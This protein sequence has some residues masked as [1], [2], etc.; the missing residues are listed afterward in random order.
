MTVYTH[1]WRSRMFMWSAF[2]CQLN[3]QHHLDLCH[4]TQCRNEQ[5]Y[6]CGSVA[7]SSLPWPISNSYEKSHQSLRSWKGAGTWT[8]PWGSAPACSLWCGCCIR[9]KG[10]RTQSGLQGC[11]PSRH[12]RFPQCR[13]QT[14]AGRTFHLDHAC[15]LRCTWSDSGPEGQFYQSHAPAFMSVNYIFSSVWE[16][17]LLQAESLAIAFFFNLVS[18]FYMH[19]CF[20][21]YCSQDLYGSTNKV[22][23]TT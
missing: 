3:Y 17:W 2:T 1:Q 14:A 20:V 11:R 9:R 21:P 19:F 4:M 5:S 13:P 8:W 15:S 12:S 6:W 22:L 7:F 10:L 16:N 23:E 18:W